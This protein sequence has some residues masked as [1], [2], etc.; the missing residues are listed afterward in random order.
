M[1]RSFRGTAPGSKRRVVIDASIV[2]DLFAAPDDRRAGIAEE[3]TSWIERGLVAAYAPRILVVEVAGVLSRRLEPRDVEVALAAVEPLLN[4]LPEEAIYDVAVEVA[5]RTGL[6]R[7]T[8][9][10]LQRP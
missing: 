4:L 6:A 9:I 8:R 5:R 7:Q 3:V 1:S 2:V 10:T